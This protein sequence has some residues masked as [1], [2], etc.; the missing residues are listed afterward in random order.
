MKNKNYLILDAVLEEAK[1]QFLNRGFRHANIDELVQKI[2]ISKTTFYKY[3][4]SKEFLYQQT[5]ENHLTQF[6][7]IL[8]GKI[9]KVLNSNKE[10]FIK[11]FIEIMK[12]AS[13]F[14][15]IT[16]KLLT[17]QEE[18]RFPHL[19]TKI[20]DFGKKQIEKNFYLILE[21]GRKLEIISSNFN[22]EI[23]FHIISVSLVN[24]ISLSSKLSKINNI[25][26]LFYDYFAIIFNGILNENFKTLFD[27]Q[28][29]IIRYE[30]F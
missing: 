19:R 25:S 6:Q 16:S 29:T 9:K 7:K 13:E 17:K 28:I 4:P 30:N 11:V 14:I 21:K 10:N 2:G 18:T 26:N 27:K 24:I 8:K 3:F 22:D 15:Q 20:Q 12:I 23:L 1:S 5:I